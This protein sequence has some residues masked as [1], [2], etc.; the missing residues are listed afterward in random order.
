MASN[1]GGDQGM[2]DEWGKAMRGGPK[3]YSNFDYAAMLTETILL[4]NVAMP[5]AASC[6]SGTAPS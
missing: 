6:W 4:G 2:K 1:N 3:A 5:P